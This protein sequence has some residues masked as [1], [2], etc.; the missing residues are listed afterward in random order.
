MYI[1][2]YNDFRSGGSGESQNINDDLVFE[3][4]L[5]K[6]I[7]IYIDYILELVRKYHEGHREDKEI[8]ID[9][10]KAVDSSVEL[11]NASG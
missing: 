7:E 11:W 6:Q 2:L 10:E 8:L 4:E 3:M 5:I 1:D 9:I